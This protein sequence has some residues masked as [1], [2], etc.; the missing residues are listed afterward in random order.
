MLFI[1]TACFSYAYND[2]DDN[3]ETFFKRLVA[4]IFI[5]FIIVITS[6]RFWPNRDQIWFIM[7]FMIIGLFVI[8]A[9]DI[10]K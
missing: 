10:K 6:S 4:N 1:V 9:I 5:I 8:D 3:T 7:F 2:D